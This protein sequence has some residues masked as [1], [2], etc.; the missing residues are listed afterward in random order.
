MGT[1]QCF[2]F[3]VPNV[4]GGS[5]S[6]ENVRVISTSELM[7]VSGSMALQIRDQP[8][9]TEVEIRTRD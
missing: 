3:L 4:L 1:E 8:D 9:G 7:R 5:Y 2:C 6:I